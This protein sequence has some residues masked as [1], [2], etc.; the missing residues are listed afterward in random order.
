MFY[1][2]DTSDCPLPCRTFSTEV[3]FISESDDYHG[4]VLNFL[5][6]V[7]VDNLDLIWLIILS[8]LEGDHNG[9]DDTDP[10]QLHVGRKI[11]TRL[12][13][14]PQRLR[15]PFRLLKTTKDSLHFSDD[16]YHPLDK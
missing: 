5:P 10:E 13:Q 1:G 8:H 12:L 16:P 3:K 9:D 14:D 15:H 6:T 2:V 4:L 11:L 7:E